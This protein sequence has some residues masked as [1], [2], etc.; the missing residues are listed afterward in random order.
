MQNE[1]WGRGIGSL[2]L[3]VFGIG[4][5]LQH[6]QVFPYHDDWGYA[7]LSYVTDQ[8]GFVGQHFSQ[9]QLLSF[10]YDEYLH[11]SPRFLAFFVQINLF[12]L[13]LDAVRLTQVAMLLAWL[14]LSVRL[15]SGRSRHP[16][17]A[18]GV[19]VF[20]AWPDFITV[21]GLY[22]FSASIAYM[23]GVVP[24][25]L[26]AWWL[27]CDASLS[28]RAVVMLALAALFQEQMAV[29]VLG[30]MMSF[31]LIRRL[32]GD[33]LPLSR[34]ALRFVPVLM[35]FG[36]VIF[37][38]GNF[39]RQSGSSPEGALVEQAAANLGRLGELIA[40][41][42]SGVLFWIMVLTCVMLLAW[43]TLAHSERRG[44]RLMLLAGMVVAI[45]LS[46]VLPALALLGAGVVWAVL[47]VHRCWGAPEVAVVAALLAGA[48]ASLALLLVAPG[49]SGRSLLIF[50]ALVLTPV[51]YSLYSVSGSLWRRRAGVAIIILILP[52]AAMDTFEVFEGYASNAPIHRL[53]QARLLVLSHEVRAGKAVPESVT[54][55]RLPDDRYAET[56]PYQRPLIE[57]WMK[58][59]YALP[60]SLELRWQ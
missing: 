9:W 47:L 27:R 59:Y 33:P 55:T 53:N 6:W 31:A 58:K 23:W 30:M 14:A 4:L 12:K 26:G 37:A 11:W 49:V 5:C 50:Y 41:S 10:L 8:T 44:W 46:I 56:M 36:L 32:D 7:V 1:W 21:G 35:A 54:L 34:L 51:L 22:W 16:L 40:G 19:V 29:A 42:S 2:L 48:F 15:V 28:W 38:P 52:V 24:L 20:L 60:P 3:L 18:V 39:A 45:L 43:E 17:V 13:G 25:L 57:T